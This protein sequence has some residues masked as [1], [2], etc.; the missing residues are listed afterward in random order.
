MEVIKTKSADS[1]VSSNMDSKYSFENMVQF[2]NKI[3]IIETRL[4]FSF[5]KDNLFQKEGS[6]VKILMSLK[7]MINDIFHLK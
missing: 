3:Y 1:T 6:T 4:T 5:D 7:N 2:Q